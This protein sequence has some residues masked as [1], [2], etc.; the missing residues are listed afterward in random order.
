MST[1]TN[2]NEARE[3]EAFE[4]WCESHG[5][6]AGPLRKR[7]PA[8]AAWLARASLEATSSAPIGDSTDSGL[9]RAVAAQASGPA[10]GEE[11]DS[12]LDERVRLAEQ[13]MADLCGDAPATTEPAQ[14]DY[15]TGEAT[16][17]DKAIYASIAANCHVE[18]RAPISDE[19]IAELWLR[20]RRHE[21]GGQ[22]VGSAI[23]FARALLSEA[24]ASASQRDS[25]TEEHDDY[26]PK[27]GEAGMTVSCGDPD[28]GLCWRDEDDDALT[29]VYME[30]R[31]DERRDAGR[32]VQ[33][34]LDAIGLCLMGMAKYNTRRNGFLS[35][36]TTD[37][38]R[39]DSR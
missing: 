32:L 34:S 26:C 2:P 4:R 6:I 35:E 12:F 31:A 23:E 11:D 13:F 10:E 21:V 38:P 39:G 30:G 18:A 1:S 19:R 29:A 7:D 24:V 33:A 5:F 17:G 8:W 3:R 20:H 22:M 15:R 25:L 16:T 14:A 9:D 27:C 28:C 36:A 37:Q